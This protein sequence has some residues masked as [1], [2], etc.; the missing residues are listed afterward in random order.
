MKTKLKTFLAAALVAG[1]GVSAWAE[2]APEEEDASVVLAFFL[3]S[4]T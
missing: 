1:A 2:D 4:E 3:I